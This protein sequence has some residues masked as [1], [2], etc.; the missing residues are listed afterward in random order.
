MEL[1]DYRWRELRGG[2][3]EIYDPRPALGRLVSGTDVDG[4]W[5]ELWQEL[6]H[7]GDIG[8][9]SYAAVTVLADIYQSKPVTDWNLFSLVSTIEVERHRKTN[10]PVPHWL[11]NDYDRAW[12]QLLD[13]AIK[14]LRRD[15]DI[16]T[17]QS[18]L[19][20]IA[21]GKNAL[22]LGALISWLDSSELD[23]I[24]E[25]KMSWPDLYNDTAE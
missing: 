11:Q 22:K 15:L 3:K 23:E 18:A 19:A 13:L 5:N 16:Y 9:S 24:V 6:H 1:D 2:Y 4:A 7:Q 8:E 17:L 10:P 21:I 12:E 25:D 14:S 20:V